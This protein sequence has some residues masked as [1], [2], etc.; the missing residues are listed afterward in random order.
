[1]KGF[2]RSY[3]EPKPH[4]FFE[5]RTITIDDLQGDWINSDSQNLNVQGNMV[6]F[7]N[8]ETMYEI[9]ETGDQFVLEGWTLK[10]DSTLAIWKQENQTDVFWSKVIILPSKFAIFL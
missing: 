2:P 7:I 10:K 6:E 5:G 1:M 4:A 9:E 3:F 8:C